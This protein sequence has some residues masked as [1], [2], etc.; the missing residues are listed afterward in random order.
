[1]RRALVLVAA[2]AACRPPTAEE[3]RAACT[4]VHAADPHSGVVDAVCA[5]AEEIADMVN[6]VSTLREVKASDAGADASAKKIAVCTPIGSVLCADP[7]E[8]TIAI[9]FIAAKRL[10]R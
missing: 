9:R 4:L 1:M 8:A 6:L 3:A 5:N 7:T 2:L 10:S